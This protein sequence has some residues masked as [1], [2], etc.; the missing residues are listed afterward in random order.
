MNAMHTLLLPLSS[1]CR[2]RA[3]GLLAFWVL[4]STMAF[5]QAPGT[6]TDEIAGLRSSF[7]RLAPTL[8]NTPFKRPMTLESTDD[9]GVL[10]ANLYALLDQPFTKTSQV[11]KST[12]QWCGIL[13]LHLYTR[14]CA[15]EMVS[16]NAGPLTPIIK[17]AMSRTHDQPLADADRLSFTYQLRIATADALDVRLNADTGPY[18]T[19]N[20]RIALRAIPVEGGRK[21]FLQLSYGYSYGVAARLAL[22][23]YLATFG[24]SKVGFS[25][26][27]T[28]P[29]DA[30]TYI[31]GTRGLIERNTMRYY[32]GIEAYLASLSLPPAQQLDKRLIDWFD[33]SEHYARQLHEVDRATYIAAKRSE[34]Q[35]LLMPASP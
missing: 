21:T 1:L 31:G 15:V 24:R 11:F 23:A 18:G 22:Q 12:T 14:H 28:G 25:T 10:Q 6:A 5:A 33:A 32:L 17:V 13:M 16:G 27:G 20:Y 26:T 9:A 35:R 7:Q 8:E 29:G 30:P 3:S 4:A 2:S 19:R 34:H